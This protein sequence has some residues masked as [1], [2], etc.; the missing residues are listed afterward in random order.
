MTYYALITRRGANMMVR[1][2]EVINGFVFDDRCLI[3][4]MFFFFRWYAMLISV[5]RLISSWCIRFLW[6]LLVRIFLVFE[7][8]YRWLSLHIIWLRVIYWL[9]IFEVGHGC[10]SFSIILRF[11]LALATIVDHSYRFVVLGRVAPYRC[12]LQLLIELTLIEIHCFTFALDNCLCVI[13]LLHPLRYASHFFN[14]EII[15]IMIGKVDRA[16]SKSAVRVLGAY[17]FISILARCH[18][19]LLLDWFKY[20]Y[21]DEALSAFLVIMG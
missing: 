2:A 11:S 1:L 9:N 10:F 3:V 18:K 6:W 19:V 12:S 7:R 21:L 8:A 20:I 15:F 5:T 14:S 4:D 16:V 13:E 17:H